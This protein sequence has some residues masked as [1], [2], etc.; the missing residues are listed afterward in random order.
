MATVTAPSS[1]VSF[2]H[3][4]ASLGI[5]SLDLDT[6]IATNG[7][8]ATQTV[9]GNSVASVGTVTFTDGTTEQLDDVTYGTS[10]GAGP[11]TVAPTATLELPGEHRMRRSTSP[12][13]REH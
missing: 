13:R 3:S 11:L 10:A 4:L 2:T 1:K 9:G 7:P 12:A 8:P 5:Q 6:T